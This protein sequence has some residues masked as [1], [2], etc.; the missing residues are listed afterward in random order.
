M[1]GTVRRGAG[2]EQGVTGPFSFPV[3]EFSAMRTPTALT[4]LAIASV[5]F[6]SLLPTPEPTPVRVIETKLV[7]VPAPPNVSLLQAR[8]TSRVVLPEDGH[9]SCFPI[10]NAHGCVAW[11]TCAHVIDTVPASVLLPNGDSMPVL[12]SMRHPSRDVGVIW[13]AA[14]PSLVIEPVPLAFHE[15]ELGSDAW[16]AGYPIHLGLWLSHGLIGS[17]D[18]DGDVWT[19]V[20]L[21][22]GCSGGPIIVDGFA[23]G[24]GMGLFAGT[25]GPISVPI[26]NISCIVPVVQ[27][28]DWIEQT[29]SLDPRAK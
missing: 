21:F 5:V 22:Y 12:K 1:H 29:L 26:S 3:V 23:V 20:P 8:K 24:V 9:G 13:T 10:A 16:H 19:S 4:I 6:L 14:N 2:D 27:V 18:K 28:R 11:L 17:P 7:I 15:P 25:Q